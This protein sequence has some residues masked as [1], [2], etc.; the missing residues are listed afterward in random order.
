MSEEGLY[1]CVYLSPIFLYQTSGNPDSEFKLFPYSHKNSNDFR[2]IFGFCAHTEEP[3]IT[4]SPETRTLLVPKPFSSYSLFLLSPSC[5][6]F[7]LHPS[8]SHTIPAAA[9]P[10]T[11]LSLCIIWNATYQT[12]F[13]PVHVVLSL[14]IIRRINFSLFHYTLTMCNLLNLFKGIQ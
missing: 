8:L 5:I 4:G 3:G 1:A 10:I 13:P 9:M 14:N 12:L 7:T 11:S 6:L 2:Y